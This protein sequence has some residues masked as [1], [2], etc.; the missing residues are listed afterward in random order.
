MTQFMPIA[1]LGSELAPVIACLAC[2]MIPIAA[3]L[4]SHQRKMAMIIHGNRQSALNDQNA[5]NAQTEA[6]SAE[7]RDLKQLV[8]QQ[9][10]AID[11][12][13]TKLDKLSD[14]TVQQRLAGTQQ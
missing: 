4:T 5:A 3:I 1:D 11:S 8:Y 13:S 10:I 14:S 12:L 2:F 9:S 7:L 6:L